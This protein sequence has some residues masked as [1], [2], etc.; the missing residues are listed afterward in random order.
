MANPRYIEYVNTLPDRR[1]ARAP[2][3]Q[4]REPREL[5]HYTLRDLR[6]AS[7]V[8]AGAVDYQVRLGLTAAGVGNRR[9]EFLLDLLGALAWKMYCFPLSP[10]QDGPNVSHVPGN[11]MGAFLESVRRMVK[12]SGL[13]RRYPP[14]YLDDDVHLLASL[15]SQIHYSLLDARLNRRE[16]F[17]WYDPSLQEFC[18]A[19]WLSRFA[20]KA[21]AQ[22]LRKWCHHVRDHAARRRY[23][24]LWGFLVEMPRAVRR[25]RAWRR[26]VRVLFERRAP[27]CC[28]MIY[29]SWP[30]M[31][32]FPAGRKTLD[33]WREEFRELLHAGGAA[34]EAPRSIRDGLRPCPPQP[35]DGR[36]FFEMGSDRGGDEFPHPVELRP[37]WMHQYPVTNAQYELFDPGHSAERWAGDP[38]LPDGEVG[39][40]P[41]IKV[42]W[43]EA[44]CFA[45]WTGC[46]LPSEAQ[47]ECACLAGAPGRVFHHGDSLSAGEANFNSG[48]GRSLQIAFHQSATRTR[49][50]TGAFSTCTATSG[51]GARTGTTPTSAARNGR[52]GSTRSTAKSPRPVCCAVA[53]GAAPAGTAARR[54][55]ASSSRT[56]GRSSSD[57]ASPPAPA[58]PCS[59]PAPAAPRRARRRPEKAVG[60]ARITAGSGTGLVSGSPRT[61]FQSFPSGGG[62]RPRA[63]GRRPAPPGADPAGRALSGC[64]PGP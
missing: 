18:A 50:T 49:P 61:S 60:P 13:R 46:R 57:S 34:G 15:N 12:N 25:N 48:R 2:D 3:D 59:R 4:R 6:T 33:Q 42:S 53:A 54:A 47:W 39:D 40:H 5:R 14:A 52:P 16:P 17:R 56:G 22:C 38:P 45:A 29:R 8:F 1:A 7:H 11:Q 28:E 20:T 64:R 31:A 26:A 63:R 30:T 36:V 9:A 23:E 27:R 10:P 35:P 51:S 32:R 41:V 62:T 43:Y 55:A 44:W 21:D 19:W 24:P 37:Y 58:T